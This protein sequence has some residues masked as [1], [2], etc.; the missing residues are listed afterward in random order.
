VPCSRLPLVIAKQ[1]FRGQRF[2]LV[3]QVDSAISDHDSM[4]IEL[5]CRNC[6]AV[7]DAETSIAQALYRKY[8]AENYISFTDGGDPALC[9]CLECSNHTYVVSKGCVWCT[10]ILGECKH[11]NTQLV[12]WDISGDDMS[13]CSLCGHRLYKASKDN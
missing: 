8:G 4:Q 5:E 13:L 6:G 12:P 1:M 11:C 7:E 9:D 10:A 3:W 2:L